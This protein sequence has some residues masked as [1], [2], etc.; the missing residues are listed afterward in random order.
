MRTTVVL[1]ALLM[2]LA[3][4]VSENAPVERNED[5]STDPLPYAATFP[6]WNGTSQA[7]A[8]FTNASVASMAY[9]AYF[10]APWC[11]HCETTIDA[12]DQVLPNGTM[13]VFSMEAREE[14][15]NMSEW[16]DSTE[17]KLNRTVDRPFMLN[18]ELAKTVGVQSIPYAVFVNEQG[19]V[20]YERIGRITNL[21]DIQ[22]LWET[23]LEATFDPVTG[24]NQ[25]V[26]DPAAV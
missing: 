13:F 20:F 3:G 7:N 23:T 14:Y 16:H 17:S 11:A 24:W 12:Y 2:T 8:S 6:A 26:A 15:A 22:Y 25:T 10:S 21:T 9:M 5:H 1:I 4:C 18:P 19:Y